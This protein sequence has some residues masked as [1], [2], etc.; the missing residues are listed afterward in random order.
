M[1]NRRDAPRVC[2]VFLGGTLL[3]LLH[4]GYQGLFLD[5]AWSWAAAQLSPTQILSLSLR[6]PHPPLYYL[7]LKGLLVVFPPTEAGLR[8]LSALCS[9]AALAVMLVFVTRWWD[10]RAAVYAGWFAALSSFDIYYAQE[11]RMYTLLGFLW[12]LAY[13]LLIEALQGHSRLLIGWGFVNAMMAWTHFYGLLAVAVHLI[14]ALGLWG[15]HHLHQRS[16]PLSIRWVGVGAALAMSGTLPIIFLLRGY[17]HG[18]AGGAW[19][20]RP[21]D[22]PALFALWSAGLAAARTYFLDSP[23]LIWPSLTTLSLWTWV[24]VGT[25]VS[26]GFA[27]WGFLQGWKSGNTH[28]WGALLALLL[29]LAPVAVAFGYATMW[30]HRM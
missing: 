3:R 9:I 20:P 13:I 12:L 22:L 6:D 5:E 4:L 19:I 10:I 16:S 30:N 1:I 26:G 7:L 23:H 15:W 25:L 11:T 8:T 18:G 27:A 28:R 2:V 17:R 24:L 14:F 21:E 29:A